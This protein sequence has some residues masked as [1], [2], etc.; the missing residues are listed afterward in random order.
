MI[1]ARNILILVIIMIIFF[2]IIISYCCSYPFILKKTELHLLLPPTPN[3][4]GKKKLTKLRSVG[5]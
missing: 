3:K 4:F 5:R 2:V 1:S